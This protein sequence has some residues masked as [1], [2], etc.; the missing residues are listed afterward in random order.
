MGLKVLNILNKVYTM[1]KLLN[2]IPYI[3]VCPN[4]FIIN[5]KL[6]TN[7]E[8][9]IDKVFRNF[10]VSWSETVSLSLRLDLNIRGV[11]EDGHIYLY[12]KSWA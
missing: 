5:L 6:I 8:I 2:F 7:R 1:L 4:Q 11:V 3:Y 10:V 9:N 12:Y